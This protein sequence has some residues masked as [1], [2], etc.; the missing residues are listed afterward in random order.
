MT[1]IRI[2]VLLVDADQ[3]SAG[4]LRSLMRVAPAQADVVHAPTLPAAEDELARGGFDAVLLDPHVH[5]DPGPSAAERLLRAAPEVPIIVLTQREDD[6]AGVRALHQGAQDFLVRSEITASLLSRSLRYA[7]ERAAGRAEL[8]RRERYFRAL[9]EHAHDIVVV[10]A[11]TGEFLYQSPSVQRVL[12]YVPEELNGRNVLDLVV[13]EDR[14]RA[15]ALLRSWPP[16]LSDDFFEYRLL[17]KDGRVKVLEALGRSLY[18]DPRNGI[19]VNARDV[20]E[21]VA[22]E[23]ALRRTEDQ[24]RQAHKMEAVGRL[25]GGIAH[26][27]NNVLTAIFGYTDLLLEQLEEGDEKRTDVEEIRR[28]ADRA[29][30]LTRQLLAFSR[31]QM[32]Q[33]RLIDLNAVAENVGRML[34]RLVGTEVRVIF[35]PGPDLWPVRADPGQIEQVLVNLSVNARDAMPEGGDLVISTSNRTLGEDDVHGLPGLA[36]GE[37]VTMTVR[38]TGS[39]IPDAVKPHIFEPFFTTKAQGKGTGLGLATV[40]GIVK[41]S[42]GGIYVETDGTRGTAFTI[43]LP[44]VTESVQQPDLAPAGPPNR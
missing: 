41:Q 22:A 21:R 25:A 18:D 16:R 26:D 5:P 43:Y 40:Y 15:A 20:T 31:R 38:D 29:A 3:R 27:F 8:A 1:P 6:E 23:S 33:P 39:G 10:L 37:Y 11:T 28:A 13:P 17:H 36:P 32:M 24:L 2:R 35:R 44:R 4:F 7:R 34:S 19:V 14:E 42:G 9:T 12:G 30:T